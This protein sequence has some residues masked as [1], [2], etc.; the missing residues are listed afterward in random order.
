MKWI[1]QDFNCCLVNLRPLKMDFRYFE[2]HHGHTTPN[3]EEYRVVIVRVTLS[4]IT[5][6]SQLSKG[7]SLNEIGSLKSPSHA[8]RR[9]LWREVIQLSG[10]ITRTKRLTMCIMPWIFLHIRKCTNSVITPIH[11]VSLEL[12]R[13]R[14]IY[15]ER[16]KKLITSSGRGSL[17]STP[18]KL[19]IFGHK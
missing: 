8:S 14:G 3:L 15:T 16:Q 17:K 4:I 6:P 1:W 9:V 11:S 7:S 19:I 2:K 18:S 5:F 10:H 13:C 12:D